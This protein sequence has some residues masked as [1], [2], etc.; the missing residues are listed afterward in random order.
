M[1]RKN[2]LKGFKKPKGTNFE[3]NAVE[4]NYGNLLHIHLNVDSVQQS[5]I[6]SGEFFYLQS[7]VMQLLL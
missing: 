2:L 1:A 3:H 7:R 4:E 5:E 6:R